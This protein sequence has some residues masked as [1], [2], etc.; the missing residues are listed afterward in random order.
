MDPPS[1]V[2]HILYLPD[3]AQEEQTVEKLFEQKLMAAVCPIVQRTSGGEAT[4]SAAETETETEK[5]PAAFAGAED[6]PLSSNLRCW[7]CTLHFSSRPVSIP[8]AWAGGGGRGSPVF[9]CFCSFECAACYINTH[10]P[11]QAYPSKHWEMNRD[12]ALLRAALLGPE[13]ARSLPPIAP[14]PP[15]KALVEYG[16]EMSREAFAGEL[17]ALQSRSFP[18]VLPPMYC[19]GALGAA[20]ASRG[21]PFSPRK[22]DAP[23]AE[24]K[25]RPTVNEIFR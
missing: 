4:P 19:H 22:Q 21:G 8:A 14:A 2:P 3:I 6:W 1:P 11:P 10:F 23:P 5:I 18:E 12:L 15:M 24:G 13:K 20:G 17:A 7:S 25:E 9:G 16:G